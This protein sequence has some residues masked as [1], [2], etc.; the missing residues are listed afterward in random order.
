MTGSNDAAPGRA[1]EQLL[2]DVKAAV[3][4]VY[5]RIRTERPS[6]SVGEA[7]LDVLARVQKYGPFS[8]GRLAED[9]RVSAPSMNQSVKRLE[10]A[11][12]V[13]RAADPADGRRVLIEATETGTALA[14]E[15]RAERDAWL[16][17]HLDALGDEDRAVLRRAARLLRSFAEQ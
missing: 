10:S 3:R 6:G 16:H 12:Y 14:V 9:F 4:D 7:A 5:R 15:A 1:D 2:V 17:R 13:R 11:G 8:M